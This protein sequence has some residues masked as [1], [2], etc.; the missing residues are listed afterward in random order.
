MC[1][2]NG[3]TDFQFLTAI[4]K[5]D[6]RLLRKET[7]RLMH[8][9]Q[10]MEKFSLSL[11]DNELKDD[12]EWDHGL[13]SSILISDAPGRVTRGTLTWGGMR[14]SNWVRLMPSTS[15]HTFRQRCAYGDC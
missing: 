15:H 6:P 7:F 9:R 11:A 8:E 12:L 14:N 10:G 5:E 2:A 13:V 1:F 3:G 4:L